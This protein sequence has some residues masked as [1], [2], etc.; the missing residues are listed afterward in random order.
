MKCF[1]SLSSCVDTSSRV[2][3]LFTCI[4][5]S[6]LGVNTLNI[7]EFQVSTLHE[8]VSTLFVAQTLSSCVDTYKLYVNTFSCVN[9]SNL[10]VDIFYSRN[11]SMDTNILCRHFNF[12]VSTLLI[13]NCSL[14]ICVDSS[15]RCVDSLN[16]FG[17]HVSTP[18]EHVSPLLA[19]IYFF[20]FLGHLSIDQFQ[21]FKMSS[22]WIY[23]IFKVFDPVRFMTFSICLKRPQIIQYNFQVFMCFHMS[24]PH[25][26]MSTCLI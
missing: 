7:F 20:V 18:Q 17:F 2:W 5:T 26:H 23:T 22:L 11:N 21:S 8:H 12:H 6:M 16:F 1:Q 24:T 9:T 14:S 10:C 15:T 3:L 19:R 13:L 25:N 4:N